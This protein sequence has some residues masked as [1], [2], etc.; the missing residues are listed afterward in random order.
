MEGLFSLWLLYTRFTLTVSGRLNA[1]LTFLL[2]MMEN[3]A[4]LLFVFMCV[5]HRPQNQCIGFANKLGDR[6]PSDPPDL[7]LTEEIL[8]GK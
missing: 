2:F 5:F 7:Q 4:D 6:Q 3:K 1:D 8:V